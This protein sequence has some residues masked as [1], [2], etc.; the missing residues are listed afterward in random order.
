MFE[1]NDQDDIPDSV[2]KKMSDL[3]KNKHELREKAGELNFK[4][5]DIKDCRNFEEVDKKMNNI[6]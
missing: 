2:K 4:E 6:K 3:L 1:G 5:S